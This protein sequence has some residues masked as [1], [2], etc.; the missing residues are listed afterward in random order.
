MISHLATRVICQL[1]FRLSAAPDAKCRERLKTISSHRYRVNVRGQDL[2]L[3]TVSQR[4]RV[5]HVQA[6]LE[7]VENS[8]ETVTLLEFKQAKEALTS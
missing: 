5:R 4:R 6:T 1:N 2:R 7:S 3:L 8:S